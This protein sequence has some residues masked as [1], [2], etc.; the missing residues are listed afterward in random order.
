MER[1]Q[2]WIFGALVIAFG[3]VLLW[4]TQRGPVAPASL[5]GRVLINEPAQKQWTEIGSITAMDSS[6]LVQGWK[7]FASGSEATKPHNMKMTL[8]GEFASDSSVLLLLMDDKNFTRLRS[9]YPPLP[10]ATFK[11]GSVSAEVPGGK[12]WL[13]FFQ[14]PAQAGAAAFPTT[15]LQLGLALL[16]RLQESNTPPSRVTVHLETRFTAYATA[17]DAAAL[18]AG[19]RHES[20]HARQTKPLP[21]DHTHHAPP[22]QARPLSLP[23]FAP[24]AA[25]GPVQDA[26]GRL[27]DP[28]A[29]PLRYPEPQPDPQP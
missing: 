12:G 20:L 7:A 14:S 2:L 22:A 11:P 26:H 4:Q 10:F 3:S 9:G 21:P 1:P 6:F 16:K 24:P 25:P 19:F 23:L 27:A 18:R 8:A 15:G 28:P 5:G 29:Q 13:V 17:S